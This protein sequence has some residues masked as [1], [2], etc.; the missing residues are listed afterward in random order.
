[1]TSKFVKVKCECG[2]EQVVFSYT[3]TEIKCEKC[4]KLLAYPRGGKAVI[5]GEIVEELG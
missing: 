2:N 4:E 5:E 1:M 3:T